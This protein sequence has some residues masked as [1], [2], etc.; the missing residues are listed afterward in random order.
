MVRKRLQTHRTDRQGRFLQQSTQTGPLAGIQ[1]VRYS[2]GWISRPPANQASNAQNEEKSQTMIVKTEKLYPNT[3]AA[4]IPLQNGM[5]VLVDPDWFDRLIWFHWYAKKSFHCW[6]ACRKV[7]SG[8]KTFFLRMHRIIAETPI[9]LVCHHI[10]GD[11]LD[12]RRANLRNMDWFEHAKLYSW[13]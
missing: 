1:K 8:G 6:Y 4:R 11:T 2:A 9:D 7:T 5:V 13:R 10:N 3:P 12:N